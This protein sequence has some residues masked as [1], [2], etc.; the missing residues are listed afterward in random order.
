MSSSDRILTALLLLVVLHL[1]HPAAQSQPLLAARVIAEE[2]ITTCLSPHNGAGPMWC[3]GSPLLVR[4]ASRVFV[5]IPETGEGVPLL[6]NT[7][8]R[9]FCRDSKG[10]NLLHQ[11]DE[12][13]LREPSPLVTLPGSLFLSITPSLEPPGKHYGRCETQLL[14]F[15]LGQLSEPPAIEHPVWEG[16]PY[17]TDHSYRGVCADRMGGE[18]LWMN[19]DAKT[20]TQHVSHRKRD[21]T[22]EYIQGIDFPIR[23][24]YQQVALKK[25]AAH[26]LAI[27]DIVEPI[28][29]WQD[30]KFEQS[31]RKWDYVFRRLF[32]TYTPN[33]QEASFSKPLEID[34]LESSAGHIS[35]LD[36]WIGPEGEA[37]VL[38]LKRTVQST[39]MRDRF[40]PDLPIIQSLEYTVLKEGHIIKRETLIV[41]G[42]G[43]FEYSANYGRFH[44]T[45]D[46]RLWAVFPG[47][48]KTDS[49]VVSRLFLMQVFPTIQ[50]DGIVE[51]ELN[52]LF[53]T[54][55]TAT[56]RGGSQ[57]SWTLDLFGQFGELLRYAQIELKPT[58]E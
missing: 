16:D 24:C 25:G 39:V 36:L 52:P 3:Y 23:A 26:V 41:G 14:R 35:N 50:R 55:F 51:V 19:I 32:Y 11:P 58:G 45:P 30:Y 12:F 44:S 57:P 40:F 48:R 13:R 33:I 42:E 8:W 47:T 37:H 56:E 15:D 2:T 43:D 28:K 21:G 10:W 31:G 54:F 27:G 5:S 4:D 53:G 7:R 6:C 29:E 20:S 34:T 46:G 9:L 49:G 38:Y 17:F 1:P 22:W 18:I